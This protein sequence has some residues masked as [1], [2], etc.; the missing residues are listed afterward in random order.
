MRNLVGWCMLLGMLLL[1]GCTQAPV[2]IQAKKSNSPE[3]LLAN[4][5]NTFKEDRP[6]VSLY[7]NAVQQL[8][9]YQDAIDS[10][11]K[12][13]GEPDLATQYRLPSATRELI[14]TQLLQDPN[15]RSVDRRRERLQDIESKYFTL[16]DA[17]HLDQAFLFR[18]AAQQ[19]RIDL[20]QQGAKADAASREK[21]QLALA[22]HAFGW[23]MRQVALKER[24]PGTD[25]W[26]THDILR[27]GTGDAEERLRVYLTLLDQLEIPGCMI[28]R[29]KEVKDDEGNRRLEEF[30]WAAGV[31]IGQEVYVFEPRLGVPVRGPDGQIASLKQIKAN[32]EILAKHYPA[33]DPD[34]VT[35]AQLEKTELLLAAS[36]PALSS[37]MKD[38]QTHLEGANNRA[39]VY[40]D[41]AAQIQRFEQ[42]KT[43]F[44]TR[45]WSKAGRAGYPLL[46]MNL[47]VERE[48]YEQR[49]QAA[50]VPIHVLP[51][52]V[53]DLA[54]K[55]SP[56]NRQRLLNDF[57]GIF[58][59]VR[60]EPGG[61]RDM[62]VRHRPEAAVQRI[63]RYEST[64]D[65][66]LDGF[67][68]TEDP[69]PA[70]RTKWAANLLSLDQQLM[71]ALDRRRTVAEGS[72]QAQ[73]LDTALRNLAF[74]IETAWRDRRQDLS[75]L[76][77]EWASQD[78]RE[79]LTYFMALAKMEL[80]LRAEARGQSTTESTVAGAAGQATAA[81]LWE[82]AMTWFNRYEGIVLARPVNAWLP[83]VRTHKQTCKE[84][85]QRLRAVAGKS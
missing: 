66:A 82:S 16:V 73:E 21:E 48:G 56:P 64:L 42:A 55:L 1:V 80:A 43:G 77:M 39:V 76:S 30:P 14:D 23:V 67:N 33:N 51:D 74:G 40:E 68:R 50:V 41:V 38:L 65:D 60:L 37:R 12:N 17:N 6:T 85:L 26:P 27:R 84:A 52:W 31:L 59:R 69:T 11:R 53:L 70:M 57:A 47:H 71:Q 19:L 24:E 7:R 36:L 3:T 22:A 9:I 18:D 15:K 75:S 78:L 4:V 35:P 34:P 46:V 58:L 83:A 8:N 44:K 13:R 45:F 5:L 81:E 72:V 28:S 62:L 61:I 54:R 29:H 20:E 49:L 2:L 79:H 63:L 32:A 10:E 25:V